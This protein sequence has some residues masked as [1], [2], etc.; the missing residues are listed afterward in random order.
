MKKLL[1]ICLFPLSC[2]SQNIPDTCFTKQ[3]MQDILFTIDSLYELDEINQKI[4]DKQDELVQDLNSVIK[5]DS[6]QLAYQTEQTKLLKTNIDLY[7]EREKRLQPKWF[8]NKAV[9]FGSG[10]LTTLFT[11]AIINQYLK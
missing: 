2:F 9:W 11:G 3:E 4:I 7:V 6:M 1:V 5:L 8:D 10:I